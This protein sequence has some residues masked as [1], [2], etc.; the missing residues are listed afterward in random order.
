V[1]RLQQIAQHKAETAFLQALRQPAAAKAVQDKVAQVALVVPVV[2]QVV[3]QAHLAERLRLLQRKATT[4]A[5]I[6]RETL[7]ALAVAA[8]VV[9]VLS[10]V[11]EAE[12]ILT[13]YQ[14]Q[15]VQ[16]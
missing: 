14:A 9:L 5:T 2:V 10:V 7:Q 12:T 16:D 8:A 15:A 13:A 1:R 4:A 11:M 6:Q 3:E